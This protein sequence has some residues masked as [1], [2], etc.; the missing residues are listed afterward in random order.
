[1]QL[2]KEKSIREKVINKII[3]K[4]ND[5]IKAQNMLY[6]FI[7]TDRFNTYESKLTS[8]LEIGKM[9]YSLDELK[10]LRT[11]ILMIFDNEKEMK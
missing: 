10:D 9:Q 3:A 8:I 2:L 4:E 1:M 7:K 6:N 5:I 11:K